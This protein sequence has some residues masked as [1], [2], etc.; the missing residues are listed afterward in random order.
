MHST[1]DSV[2]NDG[3]LADCCSILVSQSCQ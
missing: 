1:Q 2:V 3:K